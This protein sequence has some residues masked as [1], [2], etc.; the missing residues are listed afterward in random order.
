[1]PLLDRWGIHNFLLVVCSNNNSTLHRI[2]DITTFAVYVTGSDHETNG[3]EWCQVGEKKLHSVLRECTDPE[4]TEE[5]TEGH[6]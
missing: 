2:R 4:Q 5:E 3:D 1:M 6:I